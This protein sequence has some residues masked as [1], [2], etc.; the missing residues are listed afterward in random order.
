M[1]RIVL[2]RLHHHVK[3]RQKNSRKSHSICHFQLS[4]IRRSQKLYQFDLN[5]FRT[6]LFYIARQSG[7]GFLC[8][9]F[10]RKTKLRCKTDRPEHAKGILRKP[11]HGISHTADH[12]SLQIADS[13]KG[14]HQSGHFIVGHRIDRKIAAFQILQKIRGKRY[15]LWMP[16][17]LVFSVN[18]VGCDLESL[19]LQHNRHRP[20]LDPS[21]N[22]VPEKSLD[23]L[24]SRR[25]RNV[26]VLRRSPE[27]GIAHAASDRIRF[28]SVPA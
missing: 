16:R 9:L 19:M 8:L 15:F 21:I 28:I 24:R 14:I 2:R 27:Q 26:P 13:V 22:R 10:N 20:M 17:I 11:F 12:A 23:L 5:P 6:D 1:M 4:R 18:P 7:N 3:L 25:G